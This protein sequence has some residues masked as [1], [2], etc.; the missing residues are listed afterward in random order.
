MCVCVGDTYNVNVND[1][2]MVN[3]I[4]VLFCFVL[5]LPQLSHLPGHCKCDSCQ[6]QD[7]D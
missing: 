6:A 1:N 5:F 2:G 4:T 3:G 7:E